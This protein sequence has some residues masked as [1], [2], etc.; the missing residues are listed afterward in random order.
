M[1]I[2]QMLG[3]FAATEKLEAGK[4][5][6][7]RQ[8]TEINSEVKVWANEVSGLESKLVKLEDTKDSWNQWSITYG[9]VE[10]GVRTRVSGIDI[11]SGMIQDLGALQTL[12]QT[13][14][15]IP[16]IEFAE[17]HRLDKTL[18]D[19]SVLLDLQASLQAIPR[20]PPVPSLDK[21]LSESLQAIE[22][23]L[24]SRSKLSSIPVI[25]E[26]DLQ[27]GKSLV[28]ACEAL[29]ALLEGASGLRDVEAK[30]QALEAE[31][32]KIEEELSEIRSKEIECPQCSYR[33]I[34]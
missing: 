12:T 23:I 18:E 13:L 2:N 17:I 10:E 27:E 30:L 34:P 24:V 16:M 20:I 21:G 28:S 14:K 25:P 19:L 11:L 1:Q 5:E 15:A 6:A 33:W 26:V 29:S 3:A 9:E 22:E 4:R 31:T 32:K 8:I 7:N